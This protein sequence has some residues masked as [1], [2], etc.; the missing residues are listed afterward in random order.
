MVITANI[1]N[2][3][4]TAARPMRCSS[5]INPVLTG[6]SF[7][8]RAMVP[9]QM[10][11]C[12]RPGGS[13]VADAV[14]LT[15]LG[16]ADNTDGDARAGVTAGARELVLAGVDNHASTE[17]TIAKSENGDAIVNAI[18]MRLAVVVCS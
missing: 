7:T 1:T 5:A 12:E 8:V 14:L 2:V 11:G 13:D 4:Q 10:M 9:G 18:I 16:D 3:D 6:K 15:R 17:D